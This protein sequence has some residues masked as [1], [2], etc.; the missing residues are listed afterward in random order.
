MTSYVDT[1]ER[2]QL[3]DDGCFRGLWIDDTRPVPE[4]LHALGWCWARSFHEAIMKLELM[5]FEEVSV[6]HDLASFYGNT[7][8]TGYHIV[9]WLVQRK[10]NGDYV[11]PVIHA[12]SAN[13]VGRRNME[14]TIKRYLS[15]DSPAQ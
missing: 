7:E 3:C 13:P 4:H 8:L 10:N 1:N 15:S 11:P 6:D 5:D 2:A 12:H 9:L 14:E